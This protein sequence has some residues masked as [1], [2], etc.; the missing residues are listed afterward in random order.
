MKTT[1]DQKLAAKYRCSLRTIRSWRSLGAPF[2]A[3]AEMKVWLDA[4]Q[5][6]PPALETKSGNIGQARLAKLNAET[7]RIL[8]ELELRKGTYILL[9][10]AKADA[11]TFS[12]KLRQQLESL[13]S[14]APQW[15]GLP[16]Y[17]IEKKA[18]EFIDGYCRAITE[19]LPH[20][21]VVSPST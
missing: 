2:H 6:L 4:R 11:F 3:P 7:A 16:A 18:V 1:Q 19:T 5:R 17:L 12:T 14:V 15:E 21:D 13:R 10:E 20:Q 8:F 9:S